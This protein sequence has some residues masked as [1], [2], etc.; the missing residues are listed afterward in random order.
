MI[1]IALAF[2]AGAGAVQWLPAL[3]PPAGLLLPAVAGLALARSWPPAAAVLCGFVWTAAGASRLVAQ[4][5]P[6]ARDREA[7][8]LSA[9]VIAPATVREGRVDFDVRATGARDGSAPRGALRL[10]WYGATGVPLPG[11]RWELT[12]R[13]R[14]RHG[15]A[16]AGAPA[17]ELDLLRQRIAATGYLTGGAEPLRSDEGPDGH[18]VERLRAGIAGTIGRAAHGGP[19]AAVLQGLSVGVR[20]SVPDALWEAFAVT[21]I[22]HLMAISGLHVTACALCVLIL[23][24]AVW[25]LPPC[26]RWPRRIAAEMTLVVALTAAYALL[27]GASLPALRTLAMVGAVGLVRLLRRSVPVSRVLAFAAVLL[28]AADPLALSSAGFWLSFVATAAL[29]TVLD[30][31][32]GVA[33]RIRTFLRAQAAV[34]VLLAPVLALVFGRLSLIAAPVNALAIPLFCGLLLPAVLAVTCMTVVAPDTA[35]PLWRA[36]AAALDPLWPALVELSRWPLASWSP[37]AP[38]L[39]TCAVAGLVTLAACLLPGR[40]LACAAAAALVA[41]AAGA[42]DAPPRGAFRLDVLDVGQGLAAVVQTRRHVL[43]FDTGPR[44]RGGGEAARVTLRPHLRARGLRAV[45]LLV[46]SHDDADHA[47]GAAALRQALPVRGVLAGPGPDD[48]RSHGT[49]R[50]DR[51]WQWDGVAFEVLHPPPGAGGS[52]NDRSCAMVVRGTGG[53][54]LLLADPE[55]DA[56]RQLATQGLAADV[57]LLPHHGS[58]SSSSAALVAAIGARLGIASAGFG[59]RWGMPHPEVVARWRAAGTTVLTTAEAGAVTVRIGARPGMLAVTTAR[60]ASR[61]WWRP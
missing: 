10:S 31:G 21:G 58:R 16:N 23:L 50:Q 60:G 2:A 39:A 27:A 47:G 53:A 30:A 18:P 52:D 49:C 9:D 11:E 19:S 13:L 41:L 1:S 5:W 20:G 32:P 4:D 28:I 38:S 29:L 44:W 3:P 40:G 15:F 42:A 35:E 61:R 56:E 6:C 12:A 34:T 55:A 14:C 54:A 7:M 17:R 43:V 37:A 24:R 33:E 48:R 57:V 22:A 46:I 51:R 25:R 45:D 59:N 36:L 26:A 8:S